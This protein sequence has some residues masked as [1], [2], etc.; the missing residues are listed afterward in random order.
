MATGSFGRIAVPVSLAASGNMPER[1]DGAA[2]VSIK[3]MDLK[4]TSL[5]MTGNGDVVLYPDST[6]IK[7]EALIDDCPLGE[8]V[9]EEPEPETDDQHELEAPADR[10]EL[11]SRLA[12]DFELIRQAKAAQE[13]TEPAPVNE[14]E[15]Y[16]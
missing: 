1:E 9:E 10:A 5:E 7:A 8:L 6:F 3:S 15:A 11:G 2:A 4:V 12:K 14:D 13:E 16:A